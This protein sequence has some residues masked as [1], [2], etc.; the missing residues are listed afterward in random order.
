MGYFGEGQDVVFKDPVFPKEGKSKD[1]VEKRLN[2]IWDEDANPVDG[3]VMIYATT[4][5]DHYQV[6]EVSK[7]AFTK[8]LKKNMLVK[9]VAH[10]LQTIEQE[11][12]R[13]VVEVLNAGDDARVNI[14]SGGS[15]SL[16]CAINAAYQW[17]KENRPEVKEPEI[18]AP[19]SIHAA[20]SKWCHYTG[21]KLNRVPLGPDYRADVE[22]ME[23]AVTPNTIM[24]A[25]SS[26]CWPYGLYDPIEEIAEIAQKHNLWMH[27]DGCLGGYLAPWVEKLGYKIPTKWD[28]SVP[29]VHSLSAD[30]HKYGYSAKPCSTILFKNKEFQN[31]HWFHPSDWPSGPYNT[32]AILGSFPAGSIASA[33]AVMMN[34]GEKGYL[35]LAKRFLEVRERYMAGINKIEGLKCWD[36]DLTPLLID[37]G[38]LDYFSFMSGLFERQKFVFPVYE[39]TLVQ[40]ICDPVSDEVVDGFIA[41]VGEVAKGVREG[42]VTSEYLMS[43]YM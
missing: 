16:Y 21:I 24:I 26:P 36:N 6:N 8:Y 20:F 4:L 35:D 39:P 40:F 15:E 27:S 33:W 3:H 14:T 43:K 25:G 19:Y 13:M 11:L 9:E 41:A 22:A 38:E 7:M 42:T 5:M 12:K 10:G 31:Y 23:K 29:G 17:A 2:E 30:L 28:F 18:V 1:E 37:V 32:E 34:L